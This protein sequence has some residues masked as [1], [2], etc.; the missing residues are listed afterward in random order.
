MEKRICILLILIQTALYPQE[1]ENITAEDFFDE[2]YYDFGLSGGLVIYGE[3]PKE[4]DPESSEA[5]ILNQLNGKKEERKN[6]I[7]KEF[8]EE[9]GFRKTGNAK[10]RKTKGTEKTSRILLG[11]ANA[12]SFGII[13]KSGNPHDD[14]FETEFAR[15]PEG[16]YYKFESVI[17]SSRYKETSPEIL[18]VIELEYKLQVEFCNGILM[19]SNKNY[20]TDEN[21]EKF[22]ELIFSLPDFPDS[23]LKSKIRFREE[24]PKIKAALERNRNPSDNYLQAMQNLGDSFNMN[25]NTRL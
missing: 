15:L 2:E 8:L 23:I 25:K 3:R 10:Y 1:A 12:V 19:Q 4:F 20:Y 13:P 11:L 18:I 16:E 14:F 17:Y 24:L 5:Y 7:E 22:E 21:I 6:F 9:A